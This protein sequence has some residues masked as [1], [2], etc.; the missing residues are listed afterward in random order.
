MS[1]HRK[2][3]APAWD[4]AGRPSQAAARLASSSRKPFRF[5]PT[6]KNNDVFEPQARNDFS[7]Q[8]RASQ[9]FHGDVVMV[10]PQT[11]YDT[12]PLVGGMHQPNDGGGNQQ[13]PS[14]STT[15]YFSML[16][17]DP[18]PVADNFRLPKMPPNKSKEALEHQEFMSLLAGVPNNAGKDQ[19]C[20]S[21]VQNR[22]LC[23][24]NGV[25]GE[26]PV[27]SSAVLPVS[28]AERRAQGQIT[29]LEEVAAEATFSS[30]GELS[31][32]PEAAGALLDRLCR[33]ELPDRDALGDQ[34][35]S[36]DVAG[37]TTGSVTGGQ[38]ASFSGASTTSNKKSIN[39]GVQQ[40]Q[41]GGSSSSAQISSYNRQQQFAEVDGIFLGAIETFRLLQALE[42]NRVAQWLS[43]A[44]ARRLQ[45]ERLARAGGKNGGFGSSR[46]RSSKTKEDLMG[47]AQPG[48]AV[49]DDPE[50]VNSVLEQVYGFLLCNQLQEAVSLLLLQEEQ[51]RG[52]FTHL[53]QCVTALAPPCHQRDYMEDQLCAWEASGAQEVMPPVLWKIYSL[54]AGRVGIAKIEDSPEDGKNRASSPLGTSSWH[55]RL[56]AH[57]W[58]R[59]CSKPG[60]EASLEASVRAA[61]SRNISKNST[62][63]EDINVLDEG[64]LQLALFR[65]K[66]GHLDCR[67]LAD[68]ESDAIETSWTVALL[69]RSLGK[70]GDE[71]ATRETDNEFAQLC[72]RLVLH[73]ERSGA[74][75]WAAFV[76]GWIPFADIKTRI[77]RQLL[78]QHP[79]DDEQIVDMLRAWKVP[80]RWILEAR[81]ARFEAC[82]EWTGVADTLQDLILVAEGAGE[83]AR[84]T[85][86]QLVAC[87][88]KHVFPTVVLGLV[89]RAA[90]DD[91]SG[92]GVMVLFRREQN[93][94]LTKQG[95]Q[96]GTMGDMLNQQENIVHLQHDELFQWLLDKLNFAVARDPRLQTDIEFELLTQ[97]RH[98][99]ASE[100]E[101]PFLVP[102]DL[103]SA[104]VSFS[105]DPAEWR[106][107]AVF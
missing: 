84:G 74:P 28:V 11:D 89:D 86:K 23:P 37:G 19:R 30:K 99:L 58:Y 59:N 97:Y 87:V 56:A 71:H 26:Y 83:D 17:R 3:G 107:G 10:H 82:E 34:G 24:G 67:S 106:D 5:V 60:E 91:G 39:K 15:R 42:T 95:H 63:D 52:R 101:D 54:L 65:Y 78:N 69:L 18:A 32:N 68:F 76:A 1:S 105:R 47:G 66:V 98:H 20:F 80:E 29:I 103:F 90:M 40:E 44:V 79:F 27:K 92:T 50:D 72:E 55:V 100:G 22:V 38:K 12:R 6:A 81:L 43:A 57:Y 14:T 102:S 94:N 13:Q 35:S 104:V 70:C 4:K 21:V 93:Q 48:H 25:G 49:D 45:E 8:P 36:N 9:P 2:F 53:L 85:L 46:M 62:K 75:E 16:G 41:A 96:Q 33:L 31:L 51:P 64:N 77:L 61:S 73:L 7:V 88:T